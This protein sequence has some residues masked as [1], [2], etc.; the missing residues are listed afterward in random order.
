MGT[1]NLNELL[2]ALLKKDRIFICGPSDGKTSLRVYA[3]GGALCQLPMNPKSDMEL[4]SSDYLKNYLPEKPFLFTALQKLSG[5]DEKM[6]FLLGNLDDL[7]FCMNRKFTST[8]GTEKERSQQTA[9]A[10]AHTDFDQHSGTVVCDYEF[11]LPQAMSQANFDLVT[12]SLSEKVFTL[13]EYKCNAKAC[14]GENGLAKHAKD[15]LECMNDPTTKWCKEQLLDRLR[16]MCKY[17]LLQHCPTGLEH[18]RPEDTELR[19]AFLFTSG[20]GLGDPEKAAELC[21][22]YIRKDIRDTFFYCF[23][24]SPDKADLSKMVRWNK[25][26]GD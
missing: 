11:A 18:L 4:L 15:M 7:L 22:Y 16:C 25:F 5:N 10:W 20:V 6:D 21:E 12:F 2:A 23:G 24:E 17:G 19:T 13:V 1:Y 26:K 8:K 3:Y 9:I 14:G